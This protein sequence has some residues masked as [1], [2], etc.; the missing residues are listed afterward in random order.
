[1]SFWKRSK[2]LV[3]AGVAI[4]GLAG[5]GG[6]DPAVQG[7]SGDTAVASVGA[8]A[9]TGEAAASTDGP[10]RLVPTGTRVTKSLRSPGA[11][12]VTLERPATVAA[13]LA[14]PA[15]FHPAGYALEF[16]DEFDGTSLDRTKWCT[17]YLQG[18]GTPLQVQDDA[19]IPAIGWGTL[20]FLSDEQ[21]RYVDFNTLGEAMHVVGGGTLT[22]RATQTGTDAY[23]SYQSAMIR[24]KQMFR[25]SSTTSYYITSRVMLPNV[26][27]TWPAFWLAP[28]RNPDGSVYWPP[29]I[30]IFE[31]ALNE[32]WDTAR[33]GVARRRPTPTRP[34]MQHL[35][36]MST[37][38]PSSPR[39]A[40]VPDG[41]RSA[42][43]GQKSRSASSWMATEQPVRPTSGR[44]TTA[45]SRPLHRC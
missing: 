41:W 42:S 3:L 16:A 27:G 40:C 13:V 45:R 37:G 36:T 17:R 20:D 25:P 33:T 12:T 18:G 44:A 10:A 11:V 1:M 23:A 39:P 35:S 43:N 31:G 6:G 4:G 14:A 8:E 34:P 32:T 29:E 9:P 7:A 21:Q 24:S 5:C 38:R 19:C 15:D 30:D 2:V 22:L 26:R 28:S